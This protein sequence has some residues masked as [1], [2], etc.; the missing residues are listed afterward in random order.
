MKLP[1]EIAF[2]GIEPSPAVE[3]RIR[4]LTARLETFTPHI[5]HCHV[6][7]EE[8]G[9]LGPQASTVRVA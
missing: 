1:L 4:E 9:D 2:R 7:V 8:A 6:A 3:S 5:I